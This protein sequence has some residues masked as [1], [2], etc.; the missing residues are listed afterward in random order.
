MPEGPKLT[1]PRARGLGRLAGGAAVA[2]AA[3]LLAALLVVLVG[4]GTRRDGERTPEAIRLTVVTNLPVRASVVHA[5]DEHAAD[6]TTELGDSVREADGAHA[7][8]TLVLVN[9]VHG[10][11]YEVTVPP[12]EGGAPVRVVK[13]F[14]TGHVRFRGVPLDEKGLFV[15]LNDLQVAPYAAG[16]KIELVEGPHTLE[17]RGPRLPHPVRVDVRVEPGETAEVDPP[18]GVALPP[19]R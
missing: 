19:R 17:I 14:K 10:L 15:Y 16:V 7:G 18:L 13:E 6:P 12:S 9:A 2:V 3:F 11:R 4:N 8:D 5:P 1:S